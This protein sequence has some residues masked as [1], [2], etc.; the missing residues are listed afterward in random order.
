MISTEST[1]IYVSVNGQPMGPFSLPDLASQIESGRLSREAMCARPGMTNWVPV[2]SLLSPTRGGNGTWILPTAGT[3]HGPAAIE[4]AQDEPEEIRKRFRTLITKIGAGAKLAQDPVVSKLYKGFNLTDIQEEL[5]RI[6]RIVN[7]VRKE[8]GESQALGAAHAHQFVDSG[9]LLISESEADLDRVREAVRGVMN[10]LYLAEMSGWNP[11][12]WENWDPEKNPPP[13]DL[14]KTLTVGL[15]HMPGDPILSMPFAIPFIGLHK[16]IVLSTDNSERRLDSLELMRSMVLRISVLLPQQARFLFLDPANSGNTFSWA[17]SVPNRIHDSG[18][19]YHDLEEIE[20]EFRRINRTYLNSSVTSFEQL[21]PAV[22]RNEKFHFIFVSDFPRNWDRRELEMLERVASSGSRNGTYVI[23]H[24]DATAE[25]PRDMSQF[26]GNSRVF[27]ITRNSKT[28]SGEELIYDMGPSPELQEKILEKLNLLKAPEV[29]LDFEGI[30]DIPVEQWWTGDSGGLIETPIGSRGG[31]DPI[32]VWFGLNHQGRPCVHG[33]LGAMSGAGKS[34]L[35]HVMI[36]GMVVR[37]SPE[38]LKFYLVDGK[39]GVEFRPYRDLPHAEVLSLN[40]PPELSRSLLSDLVAE[41]ERRNGI[42]R[43][44]KVQNFQQYSEKGRPAGPLPRIMLVVDEYQELFE[45][46]KDGTASQLL[47]QISGQGRSAGIHMLL[48]SQ[49]FGV[50]GMVNQTAIFSNIHLRM[51]MKMALADVQTLTEFGREG[52]ETILSCDLPGK[53]VLNDQGGNDGANLSGKVAYIE[54]RLRDEVIQKLRTRAEQAGMLRPTVVF[55]GQSQ[56]GISQNPFFQKLCS[57]QTWLEPEELRALAQ[58][59]ALQGGFDCPDWTQE[60]RPRI[61]WVGQEFNV[62]GHARIV[63]CRRASENFAV[64]GQNNHARSGIFTGLLMSFALNLGPEYT[65]F[66]LA[67]RSLPNT[68]WSEALSTLHEKFLKPA[69]F[70]SHLAKSSK[71]VEAT[72]DAL[73]NELERRKGIEETEVPNLPTIL[74]A[75]AD[76]DRHES[77]RRITDNYGMPADSP[78]GKKLQTLCQD[79]P[80]RGIHVMLSTP[81][82]KGL[83]SVIDERRT[84]PLFRHRVALQ[85]PDDESFLFVRNRSASDLK[86]F[87]ERPVCGVVLD[88]ESG[89]TTRFKS[90]IIAKLFEEMTDPTL[91]SE[92]E[93]IGR[94]IANTR[95]PV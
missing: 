91:L 88:L 5:G 32:K 53:I 56:P 51:A 57:H 52:K 4:L 67:D 27:N 86:K 73:F 84:L 26:Y 68:P 28:S 55:E 36:C 2:S 44:A 33:V 58:A 13:A 8:V 94:H 37:Y 48:A 77:L 30:I 71:D 14:P 15:L 42:F 22:R 3:S 70:P 29:K 93:E 31:F 41:M 60:E 11:E 46:D 83:T 76:P 64:V 89:K 65:Q 61:G 59:S 9:R 54:P 21:D 43:E 25:V 1:D 6:E 47:L 17:N 38:Q 19:I 12:A 23:L 82:V 62:R 72:L 90:Y 39:D 24:W 85:M 69:C 87:G 66:Y 95:R 20:R 50:P 81:T 49:R 79:G 10:T 7:N 18:D 63:L 78:A 80:G 35:F 74:F 34:N 92:I 16:A 40:S 45:G 75:F